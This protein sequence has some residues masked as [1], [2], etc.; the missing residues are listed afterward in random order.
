[1]K[2]NVTQSNLFLKK[3][4][5]EAEAVENQAIDEAL[6]GNISLQQEYHTFEDVKDTLDKVSFSPSPRVIQAI[7]NYSKNIAPAS[8]RLN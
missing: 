5:N 4:Y 3:L 1:M 8:Y 2:L 6:T 7:M